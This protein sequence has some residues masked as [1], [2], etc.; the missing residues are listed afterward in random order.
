MLWKPV[1]VTRSKP[2]NHHGAAREG[3]V[4]HPHTGG[5]DG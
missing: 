1:S 3:G 4:L 5:T 2:P